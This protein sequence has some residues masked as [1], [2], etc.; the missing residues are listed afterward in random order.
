M[1]YD[2][3]NDFLARV[4]KLNKGNSKD[5]RLSFEEAHVLAVSIGELLSQAKQKIDKTQV[6]TTS[7]SVIDGGSFPKKN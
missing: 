2:A 6:T 5:I 7:P 3:I 4:K 1:N